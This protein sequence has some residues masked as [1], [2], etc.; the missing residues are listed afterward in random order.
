MP[1]KSAAARAFP[2][3][4]GTPPQRLRPPREL[5]ATE[6]KVFADL[7]NASRPDAFRASDLPLLAT[8]CRAI[9]LERRSAQAL[10]AGDTK[11]LQPWTQACKVMST[12]AMRLRLSPQARQPHNP[13][14]PQPQQ[15]QA[16]SYYDRMYLEDDE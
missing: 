6:R 15:P 5:D 14:R 4:P 9:A 12:M 11:A 1:R 2:I 7:V 8:Y 3:I 10:A 13:S 16:T